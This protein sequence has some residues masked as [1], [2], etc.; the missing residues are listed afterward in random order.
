M[1]D[2][3]VVSFR[4]MV[5]PGGGALYLERALALKQ[6]AEAHGATLCAWSALT[7]SFDF[8]PDEL[9]EAASLAALT[10]ESVPE[11]ERFGAGIAAGEMRTL[12][13][14]GGMAKLGWGE[15][16]VTAALL[17]RDARAGE[18]LID[19]GIMERRGAELLKLGF[20]ISGERR[21]LLPAERN[22]LPPQQ[23][24]RFEASPIAVP[25]VPLPPPPRV[26]QQSYPFGSSSAAGPQSSRGSS[27]EAGDQTAELARQALLQ[28]NMAA[29]DL[30]LEQL[31]VNGEHGD[32]VDRMAGLVA[33]RRGATAE[34]LRRLRDATESVKEPAQQARARLAYAV[35]LAASGRTEGALLEALEALSRARAAEDAPGARAC[36]LFLARLSAGAGHGA[37]ASTWIKIAQGTPA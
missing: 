21:Q 10:Q 37:S 33:L 4:G 35:A 14:G 9:E 7:F 5:P 29:L 11:E 17:S 27:P 8:D 20:R 16:L 28:G 15:P 1:P 31:R 13:D 24:A 36:A 19:I 34:A 3:I 22:S 12:G 25:L 32:L 2:R 30:L 6:R 18:V 26:L 23:P